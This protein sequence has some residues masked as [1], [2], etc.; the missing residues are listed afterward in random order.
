[1]ELVKK[2]S[3]YGLNCKVIDNSKF[4][5]NKLYIFSRKVMEIENLNI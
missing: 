4:T 3:D 5:S 2:M 1:M